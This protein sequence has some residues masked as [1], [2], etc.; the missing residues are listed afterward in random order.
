M[1]HTTENPD[2]AS[3]SIR[4]ADGVIR[5][6]LNPDAYRLA[7]I[8]KTAYVFA[9]RCTALI[10]TPENGHLPLSIVFRSKMTEADALHLAQLFLQELI[11]QELREHLGEETR[12]MRSLI[13]AHAFSRTNLIRGD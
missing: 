7:A 12:A 13:L 2:S 10:G 4:F 6:L 1:D 11:D 5:I 3:P 8:Q 9:D